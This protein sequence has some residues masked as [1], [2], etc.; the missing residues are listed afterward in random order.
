MD[1]DPYNDLIT[2]NG[3][4]LFDATAFAESC[5]LISLMC[6]TECTIEKSH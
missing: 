1:G 2:P 3:I 4:N 6:M 5:E